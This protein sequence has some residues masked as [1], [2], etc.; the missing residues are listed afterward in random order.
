MCTHTHTQMQ[1]TAYKL[2]QPFLSFFLS[3]SLFL[4]KH[5]L[6]H[7]MFCL[8]VFGVNSCEIPC[9]SDCQVGEWTAW[10]PCAAPVCI[11]R[12]RRQQFVDKTN[13]SPDDQD[14]SDDDGDGN[15]ID[16]QGKQKELL[17]DINQGTEVNE[18]VLFLSLTSF[19]W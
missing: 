5:S 2:E 19:W 8:F 17:W 1:S 6:N 18:L 11:R 12:S 7:C 10:S 4:N 14:Q 15:G 16:G 13:T 3:L 9:D